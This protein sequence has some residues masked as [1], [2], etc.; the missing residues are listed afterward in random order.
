[1]NTEEIERQRLL[2]AINRTTG[3]GDTGVPTFATGDVAPDIG[4]VNA[5]LIDNLLD[6]TDFDYSK[7]GYINNPLVGG[8]VALELYNFFRHRFIRLNDIVTTNGSPTVNSASGQFKAAYS[9]PMSFVI[10]GAGAAGATLSGT[11]T[12]VSDT[13]A[14]LSTNALADLSGA[15]MWFGDT[16]SESAATAI[17]YTGHSLYAANEGTDLDIPRWAKTDG[18]I[19]LGSLTTE[20]WS[21]D[22]PFFINVVRPS[23]TLFVIC[24]IKKRASTAA[25]PNGIRMFFGVWDATAAQDRWLEGSGF[26][27][28][29]IPVGTTGATSVSYKAIGVLSDGSTIESD[30]VTITNSNAVLSASNYNRLTWTNAPGILDFKLYRLMGGVYKRIFTI[31]NGASDYNDTGGFESV[32]SGFPS[33]YNTKAI[34]YKETTPIFPS[35]DSWLAVSATL[36]VP[37]TYNTQNTT[38]KQWFRLGVVDQTTDDRSILLDRL[39]VSLLSGGWNRS[40]RDKGNISNQNPDSSPVSSDQGGGGIFQCFCSLTLIRMGNKDGTDLRPITIGKAERGM[41][42]WDGGRRM[43]RIKHVRISKVTSLWLV[44]LESGGWF[45]ATA[46]ERFITSRA[47]REGTILEDLMPGDTIVCPDEQGYVSLCPIL[48][49]QTME[50][51]FEVV[52]IEFYSGRRIYAVGNYTEKGIRWAKAHNRKANEFDEGGAFF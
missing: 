20:R 1:M 50:G 41:W 7:D 35:E 8:D 6:N 43:E 48:G 22:S 32:E 5:S 14:T 52:T 25:L 42:V 46:G 17:K 4:D 26:D 44:I 15:T 9:Y 29:V 3:E 47:D 31:T 10:Y 16:L 18:M 24:I 38:G 33:T 51:E 27:L 45:K 19:E 21:V 40:S 13:Q 2:L 36:Q 30:V 37:T 49:M 12:R 23:L 34:V 28:S 11:L 39:G